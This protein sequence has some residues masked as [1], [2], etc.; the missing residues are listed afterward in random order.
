LIPLITRGLLYGGEKMKAGRFVVWPMFFIFVVLV[1]ACASRGGQQVVSRENEY[2]RMLKVQ[3]EKTEAIERDAVL[4]DLPEMNAVDH[5]G[6]GNRFRKLGKD[7]LAFIEYRKALELNPALSHTRYKMGLL[8][9]SHGLADEA[10]KEF[11]IIERQDP[12]KG[13][14]SLGK[15]MGYFTG[16][17]MVRALAQFDRALTFN[18]TLWQA[19]GFLGLIYDREGQFAPAVMHYREG[20]RIDPRSATLY[21]DLGMSYY[22]QGEYGSAVDTYSKALAID[23]LNPKICNNLG[24]ALAKAGRY[25]EALEAFR[26]GKDEPAAYNNVGYIYITEQKYGEAAEALEKA[27]DLEPRFYL[28]AYENM[29]RAKRARSDVGAN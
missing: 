15:G 10:M 14:G 22:L 12:D 19:H 3:K 28:R 13:L 9:L 11:E 29:E 8:L 18:P 17:D 2:L 5:D 23:A 24:L 16:G 4:K 27:M 6:L 20:L 26:K 25:Q 1:A 7:A 21:N